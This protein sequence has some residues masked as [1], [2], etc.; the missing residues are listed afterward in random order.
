MQSLPLKKFVQTTGILVMILGISTSALSVYVDWNLLKQVRNQRHIIRR[1]HDD[2]LIVIP[3]IH[4]ANLH[5]EL[6][7]DRTAL[8]Y[9]THCNWE[10]T[11]DPQDFR[12]IEFAR[13]YGIKNIIQSDYKN[14]IK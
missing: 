4:S 6:L 5:E 9:Y 2:T 12:N 7:T 14:G 1:H 11:E 3:K 8:Y 10:I 13:Y